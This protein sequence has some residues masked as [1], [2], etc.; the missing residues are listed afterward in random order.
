MNRQELKDRLREMFIN[1]YGEGEVVNLEVPKLMYDRGYFDLTALRHIGGTIEMFFVNY[2]PDSF[3]WY[4]EDH[5]DI[6]G[7]NVFDRICIE[8]LSK[9]LNVQIETTESYNIIEK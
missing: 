2:A 5:V 1:R 9:C 8:V 4:G 6:A 7:N 3:E